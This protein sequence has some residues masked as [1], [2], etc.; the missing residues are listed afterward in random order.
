MA[1]NGDR[2]R[3]RAGA[4]HMDGHYPPPSPTRPAATRGRTLPNRHDIFTPPPD[5]PHQIPQRVVMPAP[6]TGAPTVAAPAPAPPDPVPQT[7]LQAILAAVAAS[8]NEANTQFSALG[9]A[10]EQTRSILENTA[11]AVAGLQT[12]QGATDQR[13]HAPAE[14][15]SEAAM[16]IETLEHPARAQPIRD[17][18]YDELSRRLCAIET[19]ASAADV[20]TLGRRLDTLENAPHPQRHTPPNVPSGPTTPEGGF[21]PRRP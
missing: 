16:R 4:R 13:V 18:R 20:S 9:S 15:Q 8:R 5:A 1:T 2:S 7:D 3:D 21:V 10:L 6:T 12:A 14:H 19:S 17:E 11:A